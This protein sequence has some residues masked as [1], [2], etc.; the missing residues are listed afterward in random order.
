LKFLSQTRGI[1]KNKYLQ[2][3]SKV[4]KLYIISA[5]KKLK[6][7]VRFKRIYNRTRKIY[8][9]NKDKRYVRISCKQRKL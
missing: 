1:R 9:R 3:Y 5:K 7:L 4:C 6:K 8:H 2:S